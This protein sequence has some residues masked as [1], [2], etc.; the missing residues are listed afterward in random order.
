MFISAAYVLDFNSK[1]S[2]E[3]TRMDG[4]SSSPLEIESRSNLAFGVGYKQNDTYS[5]EFRYQTSRDIVGNGSSGN[6]KFETLSFVLG[7]SF[8]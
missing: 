8:F 6:S 1:S 2:I 5:V 4:S 3:F 7:Y